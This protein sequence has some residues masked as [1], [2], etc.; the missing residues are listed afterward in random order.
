MNIFERQIFFPQNFTVLLLVFKK[1]TIIPS[2]SIIPPRKHHKLLHLGIVKAG[3]AFL[4]TKGWTWILS[5]SKKE[6]VKSI[7]EKSFPYATLKKK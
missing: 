4:K 6:M 5:F 3:R 1:K 7:I 2:F